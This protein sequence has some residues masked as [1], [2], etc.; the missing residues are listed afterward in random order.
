MQS[1]TNCVGCRKLRRSEVLK[2]LF[3]ILPV[4]T[5][6]FK[7]LLMSC[8]TL[9]RT[10][11]MA[12]IAIGLMLCFGGPAA[13]AQTDSRTALEGFESYAQQVVQDSKCAGFAVAV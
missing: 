10:S 3:Q 4:G 2:H 9:A 13:L 5:L 12:P 1:L 6:L 11:M 7:E 8:P